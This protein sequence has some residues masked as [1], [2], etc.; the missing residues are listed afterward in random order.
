MSSDAVLHSS[1]TLVVGGTSAVGI[2]IVRQ[3]RLAGDVVI[4]TYCNGVVDPSDTS[5]TWT[6]LDLANDASIEQLKHWLT[7]NGTRLDKVIFVAGV[8][9]GKSL[10]D[11]SVMEMDSAMDINFLGQ[12]K[13]LKAVLPFMNSPS[14]IIMMSSISGERGSYDPIYAASKGAVIAFVKSLAT[15]LPP[16]I[17][18][19]AVAPGAIAGSGMYLSLSPESQLAHRER[20]PIKELITADNLARIVLDLT[21]NHWAHANG[22]CVRIN[23]GVYV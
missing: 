19:L 9:P 2:A 13:C 7:G 3:F 5:S 10:E 18:C 6:Q 8:L 20:T 4:A 14:Q 21:R 11:Y 15:W 22:S 23:G 12:A 16:K 1:T 17:R